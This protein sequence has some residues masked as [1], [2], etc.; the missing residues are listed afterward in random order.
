MNQEEL[1]KIWMEYTDPQQLFDD[2]EKF[3]NLT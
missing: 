1:K 2:A 3:Y